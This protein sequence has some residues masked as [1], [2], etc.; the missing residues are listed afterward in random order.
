MP[1]FKLIL[2]YD[3]SKFKGWQF[4]K[5]L[6]TVMGK[7]MDACKEVFNVSD[8]ELYGSGRTD[9]GVHALYQVAHLDIKTAMPPHVIKIK[10]NDTLTAAINILHVET[11]SPNFHARYDAV[12]RSYVYHI[13]KRRTAFGKDFV[14]WIKDKLD[15][16]AMA[17]VTPM[18]LGM[19][20]YKSFG[21]QEKD[22][23]S[24]LVELKSLRIFEID[25]SILIHIVGSHFL[26]RMVRRVVGV[27]VEVGRGRMTDKDINQFFWEKSEIPSQ[28]TAPP[29]GLYLERVY[30]KG[31]QISDEPKWLVNVQ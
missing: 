2:E 21:I 15:V 8:F 11:V 16:K 27:L 28:F 10:L 9:T 7:L 20:D 30:Y 5:D 29:S 6:P 19:K 24:T 4:Q 14:W 26:W 22:K 12:A 17:D 1:R 25:D 3:G 31:E 23:E 13:S 18:F